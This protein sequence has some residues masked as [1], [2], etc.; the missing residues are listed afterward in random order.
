MD[1]VVVSETKQVFN[2]VPFWKSG[3]YFSRPAY[4][5][6]DPAKRALV[7]RSRIY[8]HVTVWEAAN[9]RVPPGF[10]IH[11]ED[12]DTG[13]NALANLSCKDATEHLR[14]H[15][16]PSMRERARANMLANAIP[17]AK[18][19]HRSEE[20]R[21]WHR[22]HAKRV[23]AKQAARPKVGLVCQQCGKAYEVSPV[24]AGRSKF[25]HQNCRARALRA[26]RRL[27]P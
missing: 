20:G 26:R 15:V 3:R 11:H 4:Q 25:C 2:G 7:E 27:S 6:K 12:L 9:G 23:A 24:V 19:W 18:D 10:H 16:T 5:G 22:S 1:P 13:N 17:A 8:L 21:T 14:D